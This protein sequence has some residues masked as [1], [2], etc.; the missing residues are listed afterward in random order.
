M[1]KIMRHILGI[2]VIVLAGYG[3]IT[4]NFSFAPF[5]IL[6]VGAFM[7]VLGVSSFKEKRR[8][9]GL[10]FIFVSVCAFIVAVVIFLL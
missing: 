7:L 6:F 9:N 3:L 10:N 8:E 5:L 2:I 4:K 1:L